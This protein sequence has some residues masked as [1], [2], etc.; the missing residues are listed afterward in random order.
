MQTMQLHKIPGPIYMLLLST[1]NEKKQAHYRHRRWS[2]PKQTPVTLN[3]PELTSLKKKKVSGLCISCL[4]INDH[5][6]VYVGEIAF[7]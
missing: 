6:M 2:K 3:D 5:C 4:T 7:G 1:L